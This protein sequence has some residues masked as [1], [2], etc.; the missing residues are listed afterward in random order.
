M[1][2]GLRQEI[3][4]SVQMSV[5]HVQFSLSIR[6]GVGVGWGG[7]DELPLVQLSDCTNVHQ[8]YSVFFVYSICLFGQAPCSI[9]CVMLMFYGRLHP[10]PDPVFNLIL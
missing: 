6:S 1:F 2:S 7:S 9:C 4:A 3:K 5:N 8:S 10:L